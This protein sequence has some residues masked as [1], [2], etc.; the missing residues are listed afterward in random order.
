[1]IKRIVYFISSPLYQRDYDRYG[2]E[3][4]KKNGFEVI[5]FNF[6]PFM[7]P[8]LYKKATQKNRYEG[9][10]QK[11]FSRKEDAISEIS[12]FTKDCF[13]ISLLRYGFETVRVYKALSKSMTPYALCLL[14]YVPTSITSETKRD[15]FLKR[16]QKIK[17]SRLLSIIKNQLFSPAHARYLRIRAPNILLT[18]GEACLDHPQQLLSDAN[19][20]IVWLH[21]FDYDIYLKKKDAPHESK[22]GFDTAVFIDA[23][24]PRFSHDAL[25]PGISS[26]LTEEK[27]YPSLC[28]FFDRLE[29]ELNVKVEIAAH[30]ASD[31]EMYPK[32]FGGRKT[33]PSQTFE[34]IKHSKFIINRNSTS[35]NFAI[36]LNKP[37][38]FHTSF[39]LETHSMSDQIRYMAH[40]LGKEP[41]NIDQSLDIDWEKELSVDKS[42]YAK[43][44]N[45]FIKKEGT[46]EDFLWQTVVDRLKEI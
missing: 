32:Y 45:K 39:E 44:K 2:A 5:F 1:M 7:F 46:K 22:L 15:S 40:S 26:P 17:L 9:D 41:V 31:H 25:I 8:Q 16:I 23:P 11:I 18:G 24:S 38:I 10:N 20:K 37:I 3:I 43:Y 4:L 34:M 30:P 28:K 42:A 35:V 36:I 19:T 6:T 29:K 12:C 33:V 13:V 27:Y 21:T 14:N